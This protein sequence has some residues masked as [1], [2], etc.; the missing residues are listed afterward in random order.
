MCRPE[1]DTVCLSKRFYKMK[2]TYYALLAFAI[3]SS[4]LIFFLHESPKISGRAI[5]ILVCIPMLIWVFQMG[6]GFLLVR[7]SRGNKVYLVIGII[8][9]ILF[10]FLLSYNSR[11]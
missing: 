10:N 2:T 8:G 9:F 4:L 6:I 5:G 1:I 7:R 11:N 3:I